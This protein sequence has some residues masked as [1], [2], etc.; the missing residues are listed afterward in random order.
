MHSPSKWKKLLYIIEGVYCL[1]Y[2]LNLN[3]VKSILINLI[4]RLVCCTP[5]SPR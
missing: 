3:N 1:L 5:C 4:N 2:L